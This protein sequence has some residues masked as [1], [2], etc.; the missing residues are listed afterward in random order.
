MVRG[1]AGAPR[2]N[3]YHLAAQATNGLRHLYADRPTS[4]HE[5]PAGDGF[6]AGHF[7]VRPDALEPAQ[8]RH[9]WDD[10]LRPG[11]YD[12]VLG[13][14]ANAVDIDHADSRQPTATAE[15]I[16]A[17]LGEPALLAGVGVVRNHE[18]APGK[19]RLDIDRAVAAASFARVHGL[20]GRSSVFDGMQ[21]Q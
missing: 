2:L 3:E 10:R 18:V 11:R 14:V 5:Q 9:G 12:H 17:L 4:E 20:P 16:D 15:E 13:R 1:E 21:A 8:A 7:T 6:H 19:R